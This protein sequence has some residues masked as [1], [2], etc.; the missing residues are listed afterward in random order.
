MKRR[1]LCLL[2]GTVAT[3][4]SVGEAATRPNIILILAD[5]LGWSDIGCYG[6]EIPT[7]HIDSLAHDGLCFTQFYNNG[8]CG[9]TRASLLTGLY[10]QQTGHA[11]DHWNQPKDHSKCVLFSEVLQRAGYHTMMVGKWQGRDSALD[12]G[13]GCFFGPMCQGK[14]SYFHEVQLNPFY[15]D[16]DP[17]ELPE[18]FYMTDA[19]NDYA[20]D[21]LREAVQR[22]D[23]FLL[24]VAHLAP[25]WPLHAREAETGA[26]RHRYRSGWNARR[27][28]RHRR[29]IKSGLVPEAW[30][31]T[32]WPKDV[33]P[34]GTYSHRRWQAER[35]AVYAAQVASIDLGLG[36]LLKIVDESDQRD[37]T[38]V[39]FLSD[40]GA[41]PYGGV[42]PTNEGSGFGPNRSN[43]Q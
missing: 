9:P 10:C 28:W 23:P 25:H 2:V 3:F 17:W 19:F 18:D 12:R 13:F 1:A 32:S 35:M 33:R 40:N 37:N 38:L 14:V 21:F 26:H 42:D 7:P 22:D 30:E 24:Y 11:G 15:L 41:S 4:G 16:R 39:M 31:P 6:S 27:A 36:R 34:A 43:D 29:Q 5:D 20:A 8:I